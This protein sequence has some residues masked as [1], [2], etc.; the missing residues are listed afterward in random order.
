MIR[1][2][3]KVKVDFG[4]TD[5]Y[6]FYKERYKESKVSRLTYNKIITE[7]NAAIIELVLNK[8]IEY[9]LPSLST[10]LT[11]RKDK[12]VSKIID[13]KVVNPTPIDWATTKKLWEQ[14]E[15]AKTKKILVKY[16]NHH[17]SGYV[18]R[19]Y[20]KKFGSSFKNRSVYKFQASRRFKR[21]LGA[22]IKDDNK[23]K[24]DTYL[25]Y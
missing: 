22:R 24:Y 2:S 20:M 13:G 8:G 14:D 7:A 16:L 3:N 23:D 11:V 10:V 25:L 21:A 4:M 19:I 17:S 5:Y 18:F 12:R 15:D 1:S 6:K 9:K